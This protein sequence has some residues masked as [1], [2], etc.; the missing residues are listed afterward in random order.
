MAVTASIEAV[1]AVRAPLFRL[2]EMAALLRDLDQ[3]ENPGDPP[4]PAAEAHALLRF[5]GP[6]TAHRWWVA[7]EGGRAVG[8][9]WIELTSRED[10]RHLCLGQVYVRPPMRRRG[11]GSALLEAA[12]AGAVADGRSSYVTWTAT[13]AG[14]AFSTRHGMRHTQDDRVQRLRP[15]D[16]PGALLDRWRSG[17]PRDE[18]LSWTGRCP[19]D[20]LVAFAAARTAMNDAPRDA[21]SQE[22]LVATPELIREMEHEADALGYTRLVCAARVPETGEVAGFTEMLVNRHRPQLAYQGDTAVLAEHRGRG[23]ARRMKAEMLVR[24][25]DDAPGVAIVETANAVV[26]PAMLAIN[27]ELGFRPHRV[28]AIYERSPISRSVSEVR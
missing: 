10:N 15:A 4:M 22:D 9:T 5:S 28:D 26:N 23:L 25:R 19:N 17:A 13:S 6:R 7:H 1:D 21:P 8:L 2:D 24:L 20:L 18:L 3:E 14:P 27:A 11:I 12:L 16:V